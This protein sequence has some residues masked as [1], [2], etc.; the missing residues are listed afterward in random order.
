MHKHKN[1]AEVMERWDGVGEEEDGQDRGQ[2]ED[3][4][5]TCRHG[6]DPAGSSASAEV[7][8]E[9]GGGALTHT[10]VQDFRGFQDGGGRTQHTHTVSL[11]HT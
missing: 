10:S 7:S 9:D 4:S 2:E 5:A 11:I 1:I 3:P 6:K 8:E